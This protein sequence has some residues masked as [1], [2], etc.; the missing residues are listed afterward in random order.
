MKSNVK[1]NLIIIGILFALLPIITT[2]LSYITDNYNKSSGYSDDIIFNNEIPKISAVSGKI[3]ID[4]NSGWLAFKSA[5]NC[6]GNGTFSEPYVIEDLIIDGKNSSS[7]IWI[8]NSNV[9][10]KIENCRVY[11]SAEYPNAG[12]VLSSVSNGL[13]INNNV[14]NNNGHGIRVSS[15]SNNEISGNTVSNNSVDGIYL[16]H[17]SNNEISGN[18]VNGAEYGEGISLGLSSDN[19][20]ISGNICENNWNGVI[21]GD[22]INNIISENTV[23][24]NDNIGIGITDSDNNIISECVISFNNRWGIS[25]WSSLYNNITGNTVNHNGDAGINVHVSLFN[26]I[27]L[28]C[29]NNTLNADDEGAINEWD[30][31]IKGNYWADY[32]GSDEDGDG[33]GDTPYIITGGS[34]DN[35][36]LMKCPISAQDG[37]IPIELIIL[38]SVISGGALIGVAALLLIRRRRKRME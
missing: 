14:S 25:L 21:L 36:P 23:N 29:F 2:N 12:I 28:N 18:S 16:T 11:N 3:H 37:G 8:A 38:I 15:S 9:Y 6:T 7:C 31:G 33:I 35:F 20:T 13:L 24:N 30:N 5:G 27:Y 1:S 34:Q 10:F 4:D 22:C 19:N 17:S 26:N 32:T